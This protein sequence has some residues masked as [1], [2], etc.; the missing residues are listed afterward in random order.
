MLAVSEANASK[1]GAPGIKPGRNSHQTRLKC[2]SFYPLRNLGNKKG[3]LIGRVNLNLRV[4]N[5][6]RNNASLYP[7]TN[8]GRQAARTR[9]EV[10]ARL[11]RGL[12]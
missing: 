9:D 6:C 2:I 12:L 8:F 4:E 5:P 3:F 11:V 7:P 1:R 10:L